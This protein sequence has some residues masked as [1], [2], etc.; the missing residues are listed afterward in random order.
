M[1]EWFSGIGNI[2]FGLAAVGF[3]AFLHRIAKPIGAALEASAKRDGA[4]ALTTV[5]KKLLDRD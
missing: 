5:I 2:L 3:V 1:V 4:C